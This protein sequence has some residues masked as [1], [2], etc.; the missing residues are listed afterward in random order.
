M[1]LI[2]FILL[3]IVI[4]L[5]VSFIVIS[6]YLR[7]KEIE[8]LNEAKLN[9]EENALIKFNHSYRLVN[10]K[11]KSIRYLRV[12]SILLGKEVKVKL[13]FT[14]KD[15]EIGICYN[16]IEDLYSIK[17]KFDLEDCGEWK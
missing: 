10:K 11:T 4:I 12:F 2:N 9:L 6:S 5:I 3:I 1:N 13:Y 16:N 15:G 8:K 14:S 17:D 7:K